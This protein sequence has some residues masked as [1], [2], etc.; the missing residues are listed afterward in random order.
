[1]LGAFSDALPASLSGASTLLW[2]LLF[3]AAARWPREFRAARARFCAR[4]AA[5]PK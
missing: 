4:A 3:A 1:M 2:L 5:T